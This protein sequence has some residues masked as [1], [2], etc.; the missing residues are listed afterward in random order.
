M[1]RLLDSLSY[2]RK[3]KCDYFKLRNPVSIEKSSYKNKRNNESSQKFFISIKKINFSKYL[4]F[5]VYLIIAIF[6]SIS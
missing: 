2:K 4:Q 6:A 1:Y 5:N 3:T